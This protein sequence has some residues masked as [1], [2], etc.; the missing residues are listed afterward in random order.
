[1]TVFLPQECIPRRAKELGQSA[2]TGTPSKWLLD[3]Y[4]E[5]VKNEFQRQQ[6]GEFRDGVYCRIVS[7]RKKGG[8]SGSQKM[9]GGAASPG[10][11]IRLMVESGDTSGAS[12]CPFIS[13]MSALQLLDRVDPLGDRNRE[14]RKQKPSPHPLISPPPPSAFLAS[15]QDKTK[16]VWAQDKHQGLLLCTQSHIILKLWD[17]LGLQNLIAP[18][19]SGKY[20]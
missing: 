18:P 11:F 14:N 20:L 17:C 12:R 4:L 8:R 16:A 6:E 19:P 10:Y 13:I 2:V 1:M 9:G 7:G 15:D 5:N 3:S